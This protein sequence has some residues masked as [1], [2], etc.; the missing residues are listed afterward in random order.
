M[1]PSKT[2]ESIL[3]YIVSAHSRQ[4]TDRVL[5]ESVEKTRKFEKRLK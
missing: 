2:K 5:N 4:M 1:S 3:P